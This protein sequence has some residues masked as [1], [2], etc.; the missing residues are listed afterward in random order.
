MGF[1]ILGIGTDLCSIIRIHSVYQK[2]GNRFVNRI[3]NPLEQEQHNRRYGQLHTKTSDIGCF[4]AK[5]FAAKEAISKAM[6]TGIGALNWHDI[7]I[8]SDHAGAPRVHLSQNG[9][10]LLNDRF[11]KLGS[12]EVYISLTDDYPYAQAFALIQGFLDT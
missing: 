8:L 3:L 2:H 12:A 9:M 10:R 4:L 1:R 11:P 7:S 6:G 5:R